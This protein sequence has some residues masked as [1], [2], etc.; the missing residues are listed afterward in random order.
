VAAV[1][2]IAGV[3]DRRAGLGKGTA[4]LLGPGYETDI[5]LRTLA[6]PIVHIRPTCPPVY[7]LQG[8]DDDIVRPDSARQLDAVLQSAGA[9][10]RLELIPKVGHN[11]IS[12]ETMTPIADWLRRQLKAM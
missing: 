4:N 8:L 5:E 3:C 7:T 1:V 9:A 11:P 6:S 2:N 10:H 12:V